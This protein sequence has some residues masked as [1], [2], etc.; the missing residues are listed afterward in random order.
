MPTYSFLNIAAT[1]VGPG[2]SFPLGS[3]AGNAEE[4]ISIEFTEDK[5]R[6]TIGADGSGMHSLNASNAGR[7]LV[8][9]LKTSP[10]NALLAQ[11]YAFQKA[12]ALNWGQ[13][14]FVLTDLIRGDDYT[15][16]DVAFAKFPRN[17]YGKEAG[18][19]EW[20]FLSAQIDPVLGS[21]ILTDAL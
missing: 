9:L 2:G 19:L 16:T 4:G 20:D 10:V 12:S 7:I 17:D 15:C 13:N 1:I 14:V 6:L 11:L 3:G 21:G 8:R 18:M 5:D